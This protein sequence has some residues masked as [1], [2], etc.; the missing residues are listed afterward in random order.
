[1]LQTGPNCSSNTHGVMME[2]FT[3]NRIWHTTCTLDFVEQNIVLIA[4]EHVLIGG[5]LGPGIT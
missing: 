2:F 4:I 3:L 5:A 1:M